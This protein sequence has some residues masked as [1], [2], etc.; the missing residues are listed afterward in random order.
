M[1]KNPTYKTFLRR[2][3]QR[4]KRIIAMRR[5]GMTYEAIAKRV[6]PTISR[7]RVRQIVSAAG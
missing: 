2:A 5:A 6:R 4:R 1:K 7:E 3:S